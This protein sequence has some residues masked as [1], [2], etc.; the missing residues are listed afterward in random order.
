MN[1]ILHI[2]KLSKVH[3]LFIIWSKM[4]KKNLIDD[5]NNENG[6]NN[7]DILDL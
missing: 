3:K 6:N 2:L 7:I 1:P 5:D 4:K